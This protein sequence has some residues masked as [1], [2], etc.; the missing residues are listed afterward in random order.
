M[1]FSKNDWTILRFSVNTVKSF[2][3]ALYLANTGISH[4]LDVE[5]TDVDLED[6]EAVQVRMERVVSAAHES[7]RAVEKG[8]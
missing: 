1:Y 7:V 4:G 3:L 2:Y 8:R 5:G 6:E